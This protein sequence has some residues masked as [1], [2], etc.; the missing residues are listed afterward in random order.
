MVEKAR[1]H[2]HH[3]LFYWVLSSSTHSYLRIHARCTGMLRVICALCGRRAQHSCNRDIAQHLGDKIMNF[4]ARLQIIKAIT[5]QSLP[6][7]QRVRKTHQEFLYDPSLNISGSRASHGWS[8]IGVPSNSD[9]CMGHGTHASGTIG[10]L[11]YGAAKN[12]T[13]HAGL[14]P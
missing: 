14:R 12:A 5:P 2:V 13:I 7:M 8:A 6:N 1:A 3:C 4:K 11:T 10:G 9:D